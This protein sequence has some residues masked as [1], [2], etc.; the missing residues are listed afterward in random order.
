[1]R[2]GR[3]AVVAVVGVHGGGSVQVMIGVSGSCVATAFG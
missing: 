2:A 1:M 3:A